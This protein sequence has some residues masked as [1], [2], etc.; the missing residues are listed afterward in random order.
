MARRAHCGGAQTKLL[1]EIYAIETA[2]DLVFLNKQ[3]ATLIAQQP[4]G[5]THK[6]HTWPRLPPKTTDP[7]Y[8]YTNSKTLRGKALSFPK[9]LA[10]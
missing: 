9:N 6:H 4:E 2:K 1:R 8:I 3:K 5:R 10:N 7:V